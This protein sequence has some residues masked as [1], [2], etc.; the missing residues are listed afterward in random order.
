MNKRI[1]RSE[2]RKKNRLQDFDYSEE[3]FYFVTLCIKDR[4]NIFGNIK[5]KKM[6]LNKWG[7]IAEKCWK[8]IPIHFQ[9]VEFGTF[10]IMP[11]HVH[12]I[13]KIGDPYNYDICRN[14]P[15]GTRHALSL[16]K[17]RKYQK[18]PTIIGSFKST[19]TRKINRLH[20]DYSFQWQRSYYDHIIQTEKS[21]EKIQEYIRLNPEQWTEDDLFKV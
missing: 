16:P 20:P 2:E 19:V 7:K 1:K 6:I 17:Q 18:L 13:I 9:N 4:E 8:D 14:H 12:G 11:N 21:L 10:I 15:V 5:N 3:E